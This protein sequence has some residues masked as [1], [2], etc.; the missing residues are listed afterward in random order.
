MLLDFNPYSMLIR[1]TLF[2]VI[3][4]T[5]ALS[6]FFVW[7]SQ[8]KNLVLRLGSTTSTQDSG[9]LDHLIP[10]YEAQT[11]VDIVVFAANDQKVIRH[12]RQAR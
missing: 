11:G 1:L 4:L 12:D 10:L 3:A 6:G 7:S 5:A 2:C 8:Q 9:L